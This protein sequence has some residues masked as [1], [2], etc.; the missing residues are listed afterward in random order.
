MTSQ[1]HGGSA[2]EPKKLFGYDVVGQLG[3][4]AAS[5][6]YS[7]TDPADGKAYVLKYVVKRDE[8]DQRFLDQLENEYEAAKNVSSPGLRKAIAI[9][10][11]RTFLRKVKSAALV[12]ELFDGT[13]LDRFQPRSIDQTID[14]FIQV[15]R[16]LDALHQKR[17]IHCDMKPANILVNT[18]GQI[19]IIDLGQACPAGTV[20]ERI[21]GT[22]DFIAPEQ[23]DLKPVAV[24]TDVFNVGATLYWALTGRRIPTLI[25][26]RKSKRL[27]LT[28]DQVVPP[29]QIRSEIPQNLSDLVME[30]IRMAP[31]DRLKDMNVLAQRLQQI[32]EDRKAP[33]PMQP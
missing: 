8:K 1:F 3:T 28:D 5:T 2:S 9:K 30:C 32:A 7:V 26:V 20:K 17:L 16:A 27:F 31:V 23:V 18:E 4:G 21:Q 14:I 24:R 6:I 10:Y 11:D 25:T 19:K 13:P 29:I 15:A 12:M 33:Q 22:P